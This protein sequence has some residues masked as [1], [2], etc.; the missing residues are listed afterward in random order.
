MRIGASRKPFAREIDFREVD[1]LVAASAQNRFERKETEASHLLERDG[2]RHG[3]FLSMHEDFDQR[4][5]CFR[6]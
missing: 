6:A 5:S 1:D 2:G 3:K 4:P